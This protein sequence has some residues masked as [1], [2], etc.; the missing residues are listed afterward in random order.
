MAKR[1]SKQSQP[2]TQ[3]QPA[4]AVQLL[5]AD[6]RQ[7]RKLFE[8]CN[9]APADEKGALTARLFATLDI[10]GKVEE[11]LIYPAVRDG[12][13]T[14]RSSDTQANGAV[15]DGDDG[16]DSEAEPLDGMELGVEEEED[17]EEDESE[18]LLATAYE[19][20]QIMKDL[21][22]QLRSVDP[23]S[24]DFCELFGELEEIVIE[25]VAEEEDEIFPWLAEHL[26][27]QAL[28]VEVQRRTVE[29]ASRSSL[30]A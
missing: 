1:M 16:N 10:H 30:A 24:D 18:E 11:E 17:E 14:E 15:D 19:C 21:I 29:L 8:Q 25:H 4:N 26:D 7:F 23:G 2:E 13:E 27:I 22:Q 3:P 20:H 6:H 12:M 28:G 5:K 9:D